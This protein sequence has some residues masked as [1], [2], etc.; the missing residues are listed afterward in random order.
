MKMRFMVAQSRLMT[1]R[2]QISQVSEML[3]SQPQTH[4][5][6]LR[7]VVMFSLAGPR[8]SGTS[9]TLVTIRSG[10]GP[11]VRTMSPVT[12]NQIDGSD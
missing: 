10:R 5:S 3:A 8:R 11:R 1:L 7:Y 9:G 4:T 12:T 2:P 6:G